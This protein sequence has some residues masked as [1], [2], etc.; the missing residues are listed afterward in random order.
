[1][2]QYYFWITTMCYV[3]GKICGYI[4]VMHLI[5]NTPF[6]GLSDND[7]NPWSTQFKILSFQP[8]L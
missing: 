5:Y 6:R 4:S 3:T 8:F 7:P 2:L 1:M